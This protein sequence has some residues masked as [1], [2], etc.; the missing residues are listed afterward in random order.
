MA[1]PQLWVPPHLIDKQVFR[2]FLYPI[3]KSVKNLMPIPVDLPEILIAGVTP[4]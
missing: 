3:E 2:R 4:V 1:D